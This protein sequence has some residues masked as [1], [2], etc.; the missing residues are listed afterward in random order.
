MN[1]PRSAFGAAGRPAKP[2]PRRLLGLLIAAWVAA[3]M[4][5]AR[6]A[7]VTVL[8]AQADEPRAFGYQVGDLVTRHVVLQV[9]AGLRLD[10]ASLP[11]LGGRGLALE[12]RSLRRENLAQGERLTLTYQVFIAPVAA[13]TFEMPSFTL[14]YRG[15]P[16]DQDLRVDAWP[17]TVAPLVPVEVSP[18]RGLGELQPD[19]AP[20]LLPTAPLQQRLAVWIAG[21]VLVAAWLAVL[22]FGLPW[23][24]RR[25]R[26]FAAAWRSVRDLRAD[27]GPDEWRA[28]CRQ[29]HAAFD[30]TAGAVLF[31]R[32]LAAFT[33]S[34]SAYAGLAGE[35]RTF[36]ALS[37][38]EFFAAAPREAGDAAWL[39]DFCKRCRDAELGA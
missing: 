24:R 15:T 35:I 21:I 27:A 31:E 3:L 2:D 39:R 4:P 14:H 19:D 12:L 26:P 10:E 6:G 22:Q 1:H 37:R 9:P 17:V 33:A 8:D 34:Q 36:F 16:R 18:R 38:R 30:A 11:R 5:S 32:D 20:A 23:W 29:M 25:A 7:D 13:R 28:A